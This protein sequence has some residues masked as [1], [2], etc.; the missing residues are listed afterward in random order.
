MRPLHT[1]LMRAGLLSAAALML[2]GCLAA[3]IPVVA[4][5]MLA[6]RDVVDESRENRVPSSALATNT[7]A[8]DTNS[9]VTSGQSAPV[10]P[11]EARIGTV[12]RTNLT[13]L[14]P[15]TGA[16]P[17]TTL[18][19]GDMFSG[20]AQYAL[21][22]L[23]ELD[24][25]D[26]AMSAVLANPGLLDGRRKECPDRPPAVLIDLDPQG[27]LMTL[28]ARALEN[29]RKAALL[30]TLRRNDVVIG[31]ISGRNAMDAGALRNALKA[32]GLDPLGEDTLLLMRYT[33]D[34][35]QS[36]RAEFAKDYCLLAIAGDAPSDFDELYNYLKDPS[37][38]TPLEAVYG[39]GWFLISPLMMNQQDSN[40]GG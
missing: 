22:Q 24:G 35:K 18:P 2:Q 15:P 21:G 27:G 1:H 37:A 7:A 23:D 39:K 4:G 30:E 17:E 13:E 32:S 28:G 26:P 12:E 10:S 36:R 33:A 8:V 38:A 20:F 9:T 31:W 40:N 19:G 6:T 5:G 25:K 29:P 11:I 14:P 34:R 3:A 16:G